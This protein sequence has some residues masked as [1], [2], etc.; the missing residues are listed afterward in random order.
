[1]TASDTAFGRA[2]SGERLSLRFLSPDDAPAL[3]RSV[4]DPA[5]M[6]FW[7]PG[8]DG[9]IAETARR[10]ADINEHWSEHGFGDWAVVGKPDG[11][12]IGFAGLHHIAEM[13]HVNVGY[14][15]ERGR[16]RQGLGSELCRLVLAYGFR[17]LDLPE[18][19][20]V[21]DPRNVASIA[22]VEKYGLCLRS[23]LTWSGRERVMYAI[24]QEKWLRSLGREKP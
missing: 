16:W 8:P 18:I 22:L 13:D 23:R 1:V 9:D 6:R 11:G 5:V 17:T 2:P 14:V 20:A 21:I 19:V 12:V 15:L 3:Y 7:A 10:I 4:G 24:T